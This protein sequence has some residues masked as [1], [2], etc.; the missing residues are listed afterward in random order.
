MSNI[1]LVVTHDGRPSGKIN[2]VISGL[3]PSSEI[4]Y[5]S[6]QAM[7]KEVPKDVK[8]IFLNRTPGN[9]FKPGASWDDIPVK[10][11]LWNR[12]GSSAGS[13]PEM[14]VTALSMRKTP[15]LWN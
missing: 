9:Y 7:P 1:A 3:K 11:L 10:R 12:D 2:Q 13:R 4:K 8:N 6:A 5:L 14:S 15:Y